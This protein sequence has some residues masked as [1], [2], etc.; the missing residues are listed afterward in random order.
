MTPTRRS[1]RTP[2]CPWV[3]PSLTYFARARGAPLRTRARERRR[4]GAARRLLSDTRVSDGR[5]PFGQ[6]Q[7]PLAPPARTLAR[8]EDTLTV[9]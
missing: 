2:C 7:C 4:P 6:L 5:T 3:R 9:C 1:R 8:Q